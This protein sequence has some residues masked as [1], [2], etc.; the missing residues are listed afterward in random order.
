MTA[1]PFNWLEASYFYYRPRDLIWEGTDR[2]GDYL[3]KGFNVKALYRPKNRNFPNIAICLLYT[4][5][6]ADE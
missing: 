1:S 6:A 3:D 4:S 5:D 2:R